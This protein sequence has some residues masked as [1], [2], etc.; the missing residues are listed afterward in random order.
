MFVVHS[1]LAFDMYPHDIPTRSDTRTRCRT[2][3]RFGTLC[4]ERLFRG[5]KAAGMFICLPLLPPAGS[6]LRPTT[7]TPADVA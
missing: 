1:I 5:S 6:R 2:T 7:P 4:G 3:W